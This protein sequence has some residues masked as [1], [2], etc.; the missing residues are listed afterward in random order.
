MHVLALGVT[1]ELRK[2]TRGHLCLRLDDWP[3][4]AHPA[5]VALPDDGAEI[6][7]RLS[8]IHISEP[9]RLALI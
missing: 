4:P 1:L 3:D 9:T 5:P 7:M 6:A 2:T 8:L